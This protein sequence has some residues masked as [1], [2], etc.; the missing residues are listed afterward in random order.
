MN[1]FDLQDALSNVSINMEKARVT[2]RNTIEGYGL[3]DKPDE[4]GKRVIAEN[5]KSLYLMLEVVDD[6]CDNAEVLINNLNKRLS[7]TN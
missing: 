4:V 3:C 5:I 2:L 7:T 1:K 6:Y